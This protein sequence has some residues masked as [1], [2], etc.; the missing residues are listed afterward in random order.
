MSHDTLSD[1]LRTVRL[2]A[3]V[4]YYVSCDGEWVAEAPTSR[5]IAT[6]VMP[7][8]EHVMEYHVVTSGEGWAGL[9]GE[10]TVKM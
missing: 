2:R 8:A 7:E 4:F 6:A 5:D 3:A 9:I 1:V 10:P